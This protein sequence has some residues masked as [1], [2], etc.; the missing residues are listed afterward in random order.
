MQLWF[1]CQRDFDLAPF[2]LLIGSS[3]SSEQPSANSSSSQIADRR[4]SKDSAYSSSTISDSPGN[5]LDISNSLEDGQPSNK[6]KA[7]AH[8]SESKVGVARTSSSDGGRK[9]PALTTNSSRGRTRPTLPRKR[10]SQVERATEPAKPRKSIIKSPRSSHDGSSL[11]GPSKFA[12]QDREHRS[13]IIVSETAQRK[14]SDFELPSASSWQSV[15]SHATL[16]QNSKTSTSPSNE[17]LVIEKNFREKFLETQSK[18]KSSSTNLAAM[19]RQMRKTGSVV[20]FAD[21]VEIGPA[22]SPLKKYI[23]ASDQVVR[24][25][26]SPHS[27]SSLHRAASEGQHPRSDRD[28]GLEAAQHVE[29]RPWRPSG[30][31]RHDSIG[32]VAAVS[33]DGSDEMLL[34]LP[35]VRSQLSLGIAELKRT[36]STGELDAAAS[37][38]IAV[39]SPEIEQ[40]QD[41][42]ISGKLKKGPT[43]EESRLLAMGR[44]GGVTRAGGINLPNNLTVKGKFV[45]DDDDDS[46]DETTF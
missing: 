46:A 26:T 31:E 21:E 35:R 24:Q 12:S 27:G 33:D 39:T 15:E 45:I 30:I 2:Q 40:E 23:S 3:D 37:P 43:A 29:A 42:L 36:Q 32:S 14:I 1:Q 16:G 22:F 7:K 44:S 28:P 5:T 25:A 11:E 41:A 17:P 8:A 9:R 19:G 18:I 20:R 4:G 13:S 34:E 6:A 38:G 10:S